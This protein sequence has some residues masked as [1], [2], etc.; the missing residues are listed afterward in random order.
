MIQWC[1]EGGYSCRSWDKTYSKGFNI[2]IDIV[3][4]NIVMKI[5]VTQFLLPSY[6][7]HHCRWFIVG[8]KNIEHLII[9]I[10]NTTHGPISICFSFFSLQT[11]WY[12]LKVTYFRNV[13]LLI[14][15]RTWSTYCHNVCTLVNSLNVG[16]FQ[17]PGCECIL[18]HLSS[19]MRA[20]GR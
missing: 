19:P 17:L 4:I 20:I 16:P 14:F 10:V 13:V 8:R 2:G 7:P 1:R 9:A 6:I 18:P 15:N 11:S 5:I 3:I 12:W